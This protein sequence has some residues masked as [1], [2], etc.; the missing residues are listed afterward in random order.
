MLLHDH[1]VLISIYDY[2]SIIDSQPIS[3][4]L[5]TL[6]SDS[7]DFWNVCYLG[8]TIIYWPVKGDSGGRDEEVLHGQL[9][10]TSFNTKML[11]HNFLSNIC[12]SH[13]NFWLLIVLGIF[14]VFLGLINTSCLQL[15]MKS[16]WKDYQDDVVSMEQ[17][18]SGF[19]HIWKR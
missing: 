7:R 19:N 4:H 17:R 6:C 2:V 11:V 14:H 8:W 3:A 12:L 10:A 9:W 15:I 13:H 1:S 16:Y 18:L 5:S